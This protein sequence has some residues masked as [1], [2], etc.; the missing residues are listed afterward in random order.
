MESVQQISANVKTTK[1][2]WKKFRVS[3]V[4][5]E[6]SS[7]EVLGYFIELVNTKQIEMP[8]SR[9]RNDNQSR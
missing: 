1:E 7:G 8:V 3:C 6:S 2:S 4:E 5:N 9:K